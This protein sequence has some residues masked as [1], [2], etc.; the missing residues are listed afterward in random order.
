MPLPLMLSQEATWHGSQESI[1]P[2]ETA[3]LSG[4]RPEYLAGTWAKRVCG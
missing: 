1:S 4:S 2:S 3:C